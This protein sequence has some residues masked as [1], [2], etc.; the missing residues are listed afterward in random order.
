M[1]VALELQKELS[2]VFYPDLYIFV[3]FLIARVYLRSAASRV[4]KGHLQT[5]EW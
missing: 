5:N 4:Y 1:K 2:I 3:C